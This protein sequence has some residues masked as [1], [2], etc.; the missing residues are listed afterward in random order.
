MIMKKVLENKEV[1]VYQFGPSEKS[2]G[3]I[4]FNK[5][6]KKIIILE[7]VND[8]RISNEAY[9]HWAAQK[10]VRIYRLKGEFPNNMAVEH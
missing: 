9:E 2:M 7:Q 3:K 6:L 10:L 5:E 1:V 8:G 4:E